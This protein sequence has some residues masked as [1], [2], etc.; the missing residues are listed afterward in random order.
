MTAFKS[1]LA[2]A[3]GAFKIKEV[4]KNVIKGSYKGQRFSDNRQLEHIR[5]ICLN[6]SS[7]LSLVSKSIS[8]LQL[9]C[10]EMNSTRSAFGY[11]ELP[12][13]P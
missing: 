9:S 7:S 12:C 3:V 4:L 8:T 2:Y 5:K 13:E 10:A 11:G 1:V 6:I